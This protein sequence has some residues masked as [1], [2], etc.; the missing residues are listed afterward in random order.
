NKGAS[1]VASN[2]NPLT[3]TKGIYRN[4]ATTNILSPGSLTVM[5]S[6]DIRSD[7]SPP[8]IQTKNIFMS[9]GSNTINLF[10]YKAIDDK[11][12][13]DDLE[14]CVYISTYQ[15]SCVST[16]ENIFANAAPC[17]NQQA[18]SWQKPAET[19]TGTTIRKSG[20]D[21]TVD[22]IGLS[23]NETYYIKILVRDEEH[24]ISE[25]DVGQT[26]TTNI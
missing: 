21:L 20:N 11:I 12:D 9:P 23:P 4:D 6:I 17:N 24:N 19:G 16:K 7:I 13:T 15:S 14:Y 3:I 10:W 25:Y 18:I 5:G 2:A 8:F 26:T 1:F 22:A